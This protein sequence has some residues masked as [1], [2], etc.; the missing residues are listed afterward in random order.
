MLLSEIDESSSSKKGTQKI[1]SEN[2]NP[3]RREEVMLS[4]A[5]QASTEKDEGAGVSER[6]QHPFGK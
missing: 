6:P 2:D 1:T 3:R 4:C 5:Q